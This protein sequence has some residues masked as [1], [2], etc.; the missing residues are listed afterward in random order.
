MARVGTT[1]SPPTRPIFHCKAWG[2]KVVPFPF[3]LH[4][5]FMQEVLNAMEIKVGVFL[6]VG[7]GECLLAG[8][9]E[10]IRCVAVF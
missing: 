5:N 1:A 2:V 9:L 10:N 8:L 3:E 6:E 7:S 4:H